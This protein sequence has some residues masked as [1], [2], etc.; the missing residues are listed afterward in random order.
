MTPAILDI[1]V[2][3]IIFLSTIIAYFRGIIREIF[4]IVGLLAATLVCYKFGHLLIPE[5]NNW[6][7]VPPDGGAAAAEAVSKANPDDPIST[8]SMAAAAR[9]N[10]LIFGVVSPALAAK[11]GSYG[12]VFLIVFLL[13]ALISFSLTRFI[14]E[15]G[16]GVVDRLA[17]A[18]FGFARGFLFVLL[19]YAPCAFL[20]GVDGLPDWAKNSRSVPIL[21]QSFDYADK[22][23]D[24]KK[25]LAKAA[26]EA[27]KMMPKAEDAV[28]RQEEEELKKEISREEMKAQPPASAGGSSFFSTRP[29]AEQLK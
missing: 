9:K 16:L 27:L 21:Q 1:S 19:V 12:S 13:M 4:T 20:I 18:G 29:A 7:H 11:A 22:N 14:A 6:L 2:M 17:G 8:A 15:I 5:F 24:V 25:Q 10:E 3:L 23:F 26:S 28:K